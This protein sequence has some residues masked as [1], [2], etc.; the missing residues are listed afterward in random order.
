MVP[1]S[2][3]GSEKWKRKATLNLKMATFREVI[4]VAIAGDIE[5]S[6]ILSCLKRFDRVPDDVS[7]DLVEQMYYA[8][9]EC[10]PSNDYDFSDTE[11][12]RNHLQAILTLTKFMKDPL[13]M[14]LFDPSP[15]QISR[16]KL[17]KVIQEG[18]SEMYTAGINFISH[19]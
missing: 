14:R 19:I 2:P 5:T 4:E 12:Q 10:I 18:D 7:D 1:N 6:V 3:S 11:A 9:Y 17:S 8:L 15:Y 16:L 13:V